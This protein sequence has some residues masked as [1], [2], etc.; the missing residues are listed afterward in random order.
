[1]AV[2]VWDSIMNTLTEALNEIIL[3]LPRIIGTLIIIIIGYLVGLA[4]KKATSFVF[5]KLF[6][7]HISKT[8]L[9]KSLE[10]ASIDLG[11][12]IGS[13]LMALIMAISVVAAIDVL[14]LTG[15]IGGLILTISYALVNVTAGV[16]ILAIGIPLAILFAEYAASFLEGVFGGK[17]KV[18]V[19]LVYDITALALVVFVIALAVNVMFGYSDLLAN[20]SRVTPAFIGVSI[21]LFI[22]Y[23]IGEAIGNIVNKI[24]DSL[25]EKP[26]EKTDIGRSI[27]EM[28]IDLSSLIGGLTKAFIIVIAIVA[29]VEM[30][31]LGGLIGELVYSVALYLPRLIGGITLLTLGL[32]LGIALAKYVGKFLAIAFKERYS[33]LAKLAENLLLVGLVAVIATIALNIMMLEGTYVYPMILG[34]VIIASGIYIAGVVGKLVTEGHPSFKRLAPFLESLIIL[35]FVIVGVAG[36]FSQFTGTMNV[37]S[38]LAWGITIAFAMVLVPIV[39]YFTRLAWREASKAVDEAEK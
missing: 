24:V 28:D 1:M 36:I 29:A 39:F 3:Y 13:L 12:I 31:N 25:I 8:K 38:I 37:V 10:E 33:D 7:K 19:V 35:V 30:L 15:Y 4:V 21:I 2:D 11:G 14:Q 27:K 17:E 6:A 20:I 34:I 23:V 5:N 26:L 32:I 16:I 9:G 22:G 18:G